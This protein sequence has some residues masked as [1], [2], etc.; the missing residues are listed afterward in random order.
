MIIKLIPTTLPVEVGGIYRA[1]KVRGNYYIK[2]NGYLLKVKPTEA[3]E[4]EGKMKM[5]DFARCLKYLEILKFK[6]LLL[7]NNLTTS[8]LRMLQ[9]LKPFG[10]AFCYIF[11]GIKTKKKFE[12]KFTTC[13][14][15]KRP[16]QHPEWGRVDQRKTKSP[17]STEKPHVNCMLNSDGNLRDIKSMIKELEQIPIIDII[18]FIKRVP[19]SREKKKLICQLWHFH[20]WH[21][22]SFNK[23][24]TVI[25]HYYNDYKF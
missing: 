6:A 10:S 20:V 3:I 13:F 22:I 25:R 19:I 14:C 18:D 8:D 4:V 24:D 7:D 1:R 21:R 23:V 17:K 15:P 12:D 9:E 11:R 5:S 16:Y 2:S